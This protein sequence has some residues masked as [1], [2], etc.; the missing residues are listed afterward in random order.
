M[1]YEGVERYGGYVEVDHVGIAVESIEA[2]EPVLYALGCER[3]TDTQDEGAFRYVAYDLGRESGLELLEPTGEDGF[4]ADFLDRYGPG[5]HHVTFTVDDLDALIGVLEA[6][7]LRI[8]DY[9][10]EGYR[11]EAFLSPRNPTGALFQF[12]EYVD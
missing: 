7:G 3:R 5:L 12:W 10:D 1:E 8:V 6:N 2:A 4:V 9:R 11:K